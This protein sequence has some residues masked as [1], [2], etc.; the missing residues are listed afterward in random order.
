MNRSTWHILLGSML[1][2]A[3]AS[4]ACG[5]YEEKDDDRNDLA[6]VDEGLAIIYIDDLMHDFERISGTCRRF[7]IKL[8]DGERQH[9]L[10]TIHSVMRSITD[11]PIIASLEEDHRRQ[12]LDIKDRTG[13]NI[14]YA[15]AEVPLSYCEELAT[16][17][18]D[19]QETLGR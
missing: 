19:V 3:V 4:M 16:L 7:R 12:I 18:W 13:A 2:L 8:A 9:V 5:P 1:V 17:K 14:Y 11:N 10:P 15:S 6:D